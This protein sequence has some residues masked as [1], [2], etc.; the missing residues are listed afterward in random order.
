MVDDGQN[1]DGGVGTAKE[2]R[3]ITMVVCNLHIVGTDKVDGDTLQVE[4]V[5]ELCQRQEARELD[6]L[7]DL[8]H[9]ANNANQGYV[10]QG[11]GSDFSMKL[12]Q[13]Q[14]IELNL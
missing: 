3:V 2:D 13:V 4:T 9:L 10:L 14:W 6:R 5:G 11:Q 12:A 1:G 7:A 8:R